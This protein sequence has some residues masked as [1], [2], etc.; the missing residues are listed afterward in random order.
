MPND[1]KLGLVLGVGLV[2]TLAVLY[3]R[4]DSTASDTPEAATVNAAGAASAKPK[5]AAKPP[6]NGGKQPVKGKPTSHNS[7]EETT[8]PEAEPDS[9]ES[10]ATTSQADRDVSTLQQVGGLTVKE[11]LPAP[12]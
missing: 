3:F 10:S 1:A 11:L 4:K 7:T 12:Q 2:I 9:Q 5:P 8:T 6:A